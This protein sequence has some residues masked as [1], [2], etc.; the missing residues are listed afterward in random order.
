MIFYNLTCVK[1]YP[2][3]YAIMEGINKLISSP[4]IW[5]CRGLD[6]T[7]SMKCSKMFWLKSRNPGNGNK[8]C[9]N[10]SKFRKYFTEIWA[11][12]KDGVKNFLSYQWSHDSITSTYRV[13]ECL[14]RIFSVF[15]INVFL[16]DS[17][18]CSHK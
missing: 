9:K 18:S 4:P 5:S 13:V 1:T 14:F 8:C 2:I 17:H 10:I 7:A 6:W 12:Y 15:L 16:E 11:K 3:R